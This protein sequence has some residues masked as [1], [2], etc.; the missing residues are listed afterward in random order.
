MKTHHEQAVAF[1]VIIIGAGASGLF[2]A[3]ACG[4]RGRTVLVLDHR[5]R[6]A[7]KV[8]ISGGGRCNFTNLH[9]S[10][11]HYHSGNPH[12][13]RS[14]LARFTPR[15]MLALCR[16]HGIRHVEKEAGRL[17]CA[18]DSRKMVSLLEEECRQAGVEVLLQCGVNGAARDGDGFA[19]STRKGIFRSSSLVI[20]TGGLSYPKLGASGLGFEIARQFGHEV[21]EPRP[22]LAPFVLSAED[23]RT[24]GPLAGISLS[25]SVRCRNR[26][27]RGSMLFTHKGLSGPVMLQAS[28][29]WSAGDVL[30]IDLLPEKDIGAALT[31]KRRSR[32]ELRN[33]LAEHLP[34]RFCEAWCERM[35]PSRPLDQISDR[36][37]REISRQLHAW[38]VRPAG[39]E[40]Y[41]SAEVTAGGVDTRD[42]SSRTM[43]SMKV[44]GL[45]FIGE[46]LD[47]TGELGGYNLHW[48]WASASAAG[49]HA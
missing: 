16:K 42:I 22:A 19:V 36:E 29:S 26:E 49:D 45:Y 21:V 33:F 39:T 35:A 18:S 24:F 46:V 28:L 44:A 4:R 10:S 3:A 9:V 25:C 2:C 12:F 40:G 7:S 37:L 8:R 43:G 5:D 20:A 27:Y 41:A 13:C 14:A 34:K 38:E 15:D 23:R 17:F 11:E 1:D 47:V 32:V 31:A 30:T 48:A 6:T